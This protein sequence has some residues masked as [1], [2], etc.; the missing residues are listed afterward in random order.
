[1]FRR[2]SSACLHA[3]LP[4]HP[5]AFYHLSRPGCRSSMLK[6]KDRPSPVTILSQH[7]QEGGAHAYLAG[8]RPG[9]CAH[10]SAWLFKLDVN[11]NCSYTTLRILGK[12]MG[13]AASH[14]VSYYPCLALLPSCAKVA[15][16]I[17]Y[18]SSRVSS[19]AYYKRVH[20]FAVL[21]Q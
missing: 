6:R 4:G 1:M 12:P 16:H 2:I 13:P 20:L 3:Q 10:F 8:L 14:R 5:A 19:K 17:S 7:S 11:R 15:Q 9:A 18:S 21:Q